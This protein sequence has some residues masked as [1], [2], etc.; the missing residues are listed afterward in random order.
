[1]E[2]FHPDGPINGET[3]GELDVEAWP[4][5]RKTALTHAIRVAGP[6]TVETS[7]GPLTCE[8]GY[9]AVD[10]RGYPYPIAAGEFELIYELVVPAPAAETV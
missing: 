4:L 6:F 10:A 2:G 7:E 1:M 9:L 8:D 3:I 5:Y